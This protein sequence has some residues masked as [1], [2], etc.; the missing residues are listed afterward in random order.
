MRGIRGARHRDDLPGA[1]DGA[2]PAVHGRQPDRRGARDRTR[3]C[4]TNAARERGDRA[5]AAH[6]HPRA[7]ASASTAIPHQLSGGQRQR[8]MI[9]MALACEPKL[10]I[11]RRADDRARRDDPG[12][13]RRPARRRCRPRC[14]MAILFI[15]HDLNLV[16]RFTHRVGVMERG[17]L[18]EAARPRRCSRDPQHAYTKKLLDSRPQRE[19][20]PLAADAPMLLAAARRRRRRSRLARGWFDEA[21][22]RRRAPRRARS[23]AAARRSASSANRARAR[24]RSAWRCW[25]CSRSR[26]GRSS[27]TASASTTPRRGALR[28]MRTRDAGR[29]PGSVRLA[30]PAHDGRADRRRRAGA[31]SRRA[32]ARPSA[33]R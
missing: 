9:A 26:R 14:G 32:V 18:V 3:A 30:Q 31:A 21:Q 29:V 19:V 8:A 13:D 24:R 22:L 1:D 6:R 17:K 23:C 15:T 12:A 4:D 25:R 27:S 28:A 33:T 7:G 16:R 11:C 10:L 2:E 5:A 20:R